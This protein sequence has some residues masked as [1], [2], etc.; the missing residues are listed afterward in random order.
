MKSF[1]I[2]IWIVAVLVG[3][4]SS[5]R[6]ESFLGVPVSDPGM[7]TRV[8]DMA[9]LDDGSCVLIGYQ[10]QTDDNGNWISQSAWMS[11]VLPTGEVLWSQNPDGRPA[12][13]HAEV[14]KNQDILVVTYKYDGMT[15]ESI[16]GLRK[17]ASDG[18]VMWSMTYNLGWGIGMQIL[19]SDSILIVGTARNLM[20]GGIVTPGGDLARQFEYSSFQY[21]RFLSVGRSIFFYSEEYTSNGS[22]VRF[23]RTTLTG[24]SVHS[25]VVDAIPQVLLPRGSGFVSLVWFTKRNEY[26]SIF[27]KGMFRW[28]LHDSAGA[29]L[30]RKE[31][32]AEEGWFRDACQM[33]DGSVILVTNSHLIKFSSTGEWMWSKPYETS[34]WEDGH[35]E[36]A[37]ARRSGDNSIILAGM[38]YP[39]DTEEDRNSRAAL[40]HFDS[41]GNLLNGPE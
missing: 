9:I 16:T 8:N 23:L 33:D 26:S 17:I 38:R 22:T 10:E 20:K 41:D 5:S 35:F 15:G 29:E 28:T 25:A 12:L 24:D 27:D 21:P 13:S 18:N 1:A 14:T 40:F 11:R 3:C 34:D 30:Q 7:S 31:F 2:W 6:E 39:P 37:A 36:I 19:D 32:N 4:A